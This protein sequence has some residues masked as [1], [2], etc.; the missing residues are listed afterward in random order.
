MTDHNIVFPP[1]LPNGVWI[2]YCQICG[3]SICLDGW[4]EKTDGEWM[5]ITEWRAKNEPPKT[6]MMTEEAFH[7]RMVES[8][9]HG[10]TNRIRDERKAL[11]NLP[12]GWEPPGSRNRD[13]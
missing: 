1:A 10:Y 3:M 13:D 8:Y 12:I 11:D 7:K 5:H 9:N 4:P 2:P 6:I